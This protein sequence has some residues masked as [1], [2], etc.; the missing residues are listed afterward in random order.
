MNYVKNKISGSLKHLPFI[1]LILILAVYLDTKAIPENGW[2]GWR[3]D[4]QVL[5]SAK[6]WANDGFFKSYFLFLPQG[7]SKTVRYF[8]DP[9]L[10]QHARGITTGGFIGKRLYYTHY[11]FG[12]IIPSA[13]LMKLGIESRF[14]FRLLEI[15]FSLIGLV[16]LYWVFNLISNH[17][18]AFLGVLYY[19]VST[20][21][22]DYADSLAAMPL[23]EFLR[24][25][26]IFLSILVLKNGQKKYL[27]YL[28]WIFYFIL[29][30][31]SYDSTFFIFA[32]LVGLDIL[33]NKKF[34]WRLWTFWAAAPILAFAVQLLQNYLYLGWHNM[35][36][37]LYGTFKVQMVGSR[38]G[39]L[40]SH[41]KRLIEPFSWFFG[42]KWYLGILISII[43]IAAIKFIKKYSPLVVSEVEPNDILDLRFLYL[44]FV[45]T[46][47]NFLFF[48]SLFFYQ[49]RL[50]AVFG[51]LLIGILTVNLFKTIRQKN[52]IPRYI[53]VFGIF[54]LVLGLWFIQGKRTY[55]YIKNWPNNIWPAE[56]IGFNKKIK[57]LVSGDKVIFQMYGLDREITGSDRYPMAA[58]EDEYYINAP[59]LGFTNTKDLIR[60]FS[61]L[62]KRSEFPFNSIVIADQKS[63]IEKIKTKLKLKESFSKIDNEFILI[64]K[65]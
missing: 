17:W 8:D 48:P 21:F 63:T 37:D 1:F 33:F 38:S 46:L 18:V 7:Y 59:I 25:I 27:N 43:G 55:A 2:D 62:K 35:L 20:L 22:L 54:I 29:S 49:G 58:S 65:Q 41:L 32:W 34:N 53:L 4:A 15:L 24:A 19:S 42:V 56:S 10:R 23:E 14:W 44:G 47:F 5:L 28:I 13:L 31:S 11:P 30:L 51:S 39:F 50:V 61:Y 57:N 26:I 12:Y 6:H 3:A 45:A 9:E 64:I 36:L 16:F 52:L 40:T 60:D